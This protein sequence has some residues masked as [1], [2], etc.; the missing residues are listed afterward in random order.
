[1]WSAFHRWQP[2]LSR[3]TNRKW[4]DACAESRQTPSRRFVST[5]ADIIRSASSNN[6]SRTAAEPEES[7][8]YP[9][10]WKETE[11]M[12][13]L[14]EVYPNPENGEGTYR[15]STT[16]SSSS[17]MPLTLI[18]EESRTFILVNPLFHH[19]CRL[20]VFSCRISLCKNISAF[21]TTFP[22]RGDSNRENFALY[23][24]IGSLAE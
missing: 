9:P 10:P 17:D 7:S 15:I 3:A 1:M 24:E 23:C 13:E 18:P 11:K 16:T 6:S 12:R 20:F 22:N 2:A 21:L 8:T 5:S 14:G 4:G 19:Q